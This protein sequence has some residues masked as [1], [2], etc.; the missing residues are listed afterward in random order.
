MIYILAVIPA[1]MF[2]P[3]LWRVVNLGWAWWRR[4]LYGK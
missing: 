1:L 2:A 4:V 3:E